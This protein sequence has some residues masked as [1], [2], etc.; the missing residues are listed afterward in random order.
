MG[1]RRPQSHPF[2]ASRAARQEEVTPRRLEICSICGSPF[3][4]TRYQV[5]VDEL[6]GAAFDKVAC[7]DEAL[8]DRDWERDELAARRRRSR[9]TAG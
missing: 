2:G 7:A 6:D 8:A 1:L 3:D 4:P 9:R 5:V